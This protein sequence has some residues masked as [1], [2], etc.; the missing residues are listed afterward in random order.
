MAGSR[1]WNQMRTTNGI[2]KTPEV[3]TDLVRS[4]VA[5]AKV[6][7][8]QSPAIIQLDRERA[9]RWHAGDSSAP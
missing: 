6:L 9:A 2:A 4:A 8:E 3:I 7:E 5:L 1:C